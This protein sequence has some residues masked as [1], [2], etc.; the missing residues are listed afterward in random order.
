MPSI[1]DYMVALAAWL[2]STRMPEFALWL[3][4]QWISGFFDKN[5]WFVPS[6]Q[7]VHIL[8]VAA[9]FGSVVMMNLRLLGLAGRSRTMSQTVRR[10]LPWVWCG[11]AVLLLTG[12]GMIIAEPPRELLNPAFWTKM[13]LVTV[14]TL[15]SLWFQLSVNRNIAR[16]EL[17]HESRVA[18]RVGSAAVISLWIVIMLL[19]RWIAYAPT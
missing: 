11:L 17:T 14:A 15:L 12:L 2:R 8:A 4:K 10:Y 19:G 7:V 5:F 1:S 6:F 9:L 18:V 3:Q 16:W 13:V